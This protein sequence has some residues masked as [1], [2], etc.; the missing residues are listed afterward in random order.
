MPIRHTQNKSDAV[1][2]THWAKQI[3]L[4][5]AFMSKMRNYLLNAVKL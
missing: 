1:R 5:Y 3:D 4:A 2:C